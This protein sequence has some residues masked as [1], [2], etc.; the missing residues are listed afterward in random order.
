MTELEVA[1]DPHRAAG[2][3]R[4]G[5]WLYPLSGTGR[6]F[7]TTTGSFTPDHRKLRNVALA[8]TVR[9]GTGPFERGFLTVAD[10]DLLWLHDPVGIVGLARV[11]S[12]SGRPSPSVTFRFERGPTRVLVQDPVPM[13][14][15]RRWL[16]SLPRQPVELSHDHVLTEGLQWWLEQLD[17]RDR[18]RLSPIGVPTLREVA[19]RQ[20][21]R[22][23]DPTVAATVRALRAR[24]LAV[25]LPTGKARVADVVARNGERLVIARVVRDAGERGRRTVLESLGQLAWYGRCLADEAPK[26]GLQPDLWLIFTQPP[27]DDLGRFLEDEGRSV[28]WREGAELHLSAATAQRWPLPTTHVVSGTSPPRDAR[29]RL[30]LATG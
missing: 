9:E 8:G 17:G 7:T 11:V 21:D 23:D 30:V 6:R 26:L 27:S 13:A 24:D 10:G 5:Q 16:Q 18:H 22:L 19:A 20:R 28:A 1:P 15:L 4:V 2:P 3:E 25:G 29:P 14:L 12:H